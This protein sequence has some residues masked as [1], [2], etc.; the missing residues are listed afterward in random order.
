MDREE[1]ILRRL[2]AQHLLHKTDTQTAVKDLCGVQAQ[3]LS[4]ALHGLS[5]RCSEV[6]ADGL[7]KS[8]T[9]RGTL[10]LFS[11]DDLSLFLHEGRS[12]FLRPVDTLEADAYLSAARKA[13]F[14][15]VILDGIGQGIDHRDAL[16]TLCESCGMTESEAKSAFDPWGGLIRALCEAG[17][18]CHKVQEQ[19][20]YLLCPPFEP[21]DETSAR[22]ELLR[23]YFTH[24]GPATVKDAAYFFG[25]T[26]SQIKPY[27]SILPLKI[28]NL[29]RKEYFYIDTVSSIDWMPDCLF[30]AGF[31]QFLLGYDKT[32]SLVLPKDHLRE[33]YNLA[34]IVR[35]AVLVKGRVVG[36]WN[37]KNRKLKITL[38]S[39]A[40]RQMIA[41]AAAQQWPELKSIAFE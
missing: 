20:A 30:L 25:I 40:D 8:W 5:I 23:R 14:A 7:A 4:H 37:L 33:I 35:P 26:Q 38:L 17:K 31:D 15:D 27:L 16:K 2:S 34:G 11:V 12:H 28:T 24:F 1:M 21:M 9:N 32:E 3:F 10:H 19:K 41:D 18:I 29:S 22:L 6:C 39:P 13:Y 36:W